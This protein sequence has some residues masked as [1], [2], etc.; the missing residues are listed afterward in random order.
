M[1][2]YLRFMAP[3]MMA[4]FSLTFISCSDEPEPNAPE[5]NEP[6][7]GLVS[8]QAGILAGDDEEANAVVADL[9]LASVGRS[10]YSYHY[11]YDEDGYLETI[12]E[13]DDPGWSTSANENFKVVDNH[14][15]D[16]GE[17]WEWTST[18]NI[19]DN[20]VVS[21]PYSFNEG[22]EGTVYA[23]KGVYNFAYN[24][25]GQLSSVVWTVEWSD[26]DPKSSAQNGKWERLITIT[27]SKDGRITLVDCEESS[28]RDGEKEAFEKTVEFEYSSDVINKFYQYIPNFIEDI[29]FEDSNEHF[30]PFAYIGLLGKASSYI[31]TESITTYT[32]YWAGNEFSDSYT[33]TYSCTFNDNGTIRSSDG[34]DYTYMNIGAR[35]FFAP[36]KP[37]FG[38]NHTENGERK[39]RRSFMRNLRERHQ[40]L[41]GTK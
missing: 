6:E 34:Y 4:A 33:R 38:Q 7:N 2:K 22:E 17:W 39:S 1:K 9:R 18:F 3:A 32:K 30:L 35:S 26:S 16:N 23:E 10:D 28:E 19:S 20:R 12:S 15:Y 40:R 31:P 21:I 8:V 37:V 27:Y 11:T 41:H 13:I 29:F 25:K 36:R 5:P 14:Y 24:A